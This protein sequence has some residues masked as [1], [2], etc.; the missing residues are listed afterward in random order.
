[1]KKIL[2]VLAGLMCSV[3]GVFAKADVTVKS[4]SLAELKG[5]K[6]KIYVVWDYS[7]ATLEGKDLQNASMTRAKTQRLRL[8]SVMQ[9]IDL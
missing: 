8:K 1:M 3:A 6:E 4:G 7:H 5:T 9:N 2:L